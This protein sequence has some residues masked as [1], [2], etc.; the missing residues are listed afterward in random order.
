MGDTARTFI[1]IDIKP[2]MPI[3]DLW[4]KLRTALKGDSIK[5]VDQST[6]HL[7][8]L[9]LGDT[10]VTHIKPIANAL[11]E[12]LAGVSPFG[13]CIKGVGVFGGSNPRVVWLGVE[14]SKELDELK[15]LVDRV[16]VRFGYEDENKTF[17]P[18]LTL[19]R[20]KFLRNK[21][22]LSSVVAQFSDAIFQKVEV[23]QVTFYQSILSQQGPVYKP[24][25][26]I[27][28]GVN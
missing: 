4:Q 13:I 5:W 28:L 18:H 9:F 24:L 2:E 20:I 15:H 17:S 8:L 6:I 7:T 19:G 26:I 25:E 14:A 16:L 11:K 3:V 27:P 23:S 10:P 22:P 1:S 21:L 12:N